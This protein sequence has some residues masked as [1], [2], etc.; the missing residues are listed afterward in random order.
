MLGEISNTSRGFGIVEFEDSHGSKCSVQCSS[1]IGDYEDSMGHPGSSYIW[2][3]L[4]DASPKILASHARAH[5]IETD[6]CTGWIDFPIPNDVLLS[7]RMHLD[8]EQVQGL[9]ERLQ[10]WLKNGEF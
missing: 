10:Y 9:I 7:T 3:G 5:G 6:Q 1:A 4:D 8:R 2:L